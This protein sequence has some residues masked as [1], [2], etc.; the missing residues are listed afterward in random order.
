MTTRDRPLARQVFLLQT[1]SVAL[2]VVALVALSSW[3][4]RHN[5]FAVARTR[6]VELAQVVAMA[7]IVVDAVERN[8]ASPGLQAYADDVQRR[9]GMDFVVIMG[10]DRTRY[11]HPTA[12]R[13]G[14]PFL[15]DL[16]SAPTGGVFTQEYAG[17]LGPSVRSVVPV[18]SASGSVVGLVSVGITIQRLEGAAPARLG[19]IAAVAA[20]LLGVGALGA[21]LISNR[22][23]RQTHGLGEAELARM[24]EYYDSVLHAVREGLLLLDPAGVIQLAN[25]EG[26]RLLGLADDV[27]GRAISAVGLPDDLAARLEARALTLDELAVVGDRVLVVNQQ[28]ASYGGRD[29]G[30]VVTLR[31]RTELQRAT[32]E[33]ATIRGLTETLR[34]QN[35]EAENRMHTVVSLIELGHPERAAEFAT[36]RLASAQRLTD[37]LAVRD[38][39]DTVV[40]A[41]L[42]GKTAQASERGIDLVLDEDSH[43]AGL[44]VPEGVAVTILGNLLDNAMDA[45]AGRENPRIETLVVASSG[46]FHVE[47]EDSGPGIPEGLRDAVLEAGWTT[48][49]DTTGHGLGLALVRQVIER[50]GGRLSCGTS[51][52]GGA[53]FVVDIGDST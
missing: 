49:A 13:V 27:T 9:A 50:H 53:A 29:T 51:D 23:R 11:T 19:A 22:L 37:R 20:A 30:S 28:R 10:L 46:G 31:D 35:H 52:L 15:G 39:D 6:C 41:L 7:P 32:G 25:V 21:W 18:I 14:E 3:D 45:V 47:V 36:G 5:E 43:V 16:G 2:L 4:S 42:L 26:R 17:T 33:L 34:A 44:C 40:T 48:K 8:A 38:A 12:E 1:L 24:Y